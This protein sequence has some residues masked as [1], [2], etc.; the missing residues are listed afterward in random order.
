MMLLMT[1]LFGC[2]EEDLDTCSLSLVSSG[3]M[4]IDNGEGYVQEPDARWSSSDEMLS[5]YTIDHVSTLTLRAYGDE[6]G[7]EGADLLG[8]LPV[9][10]ELDTSQSGGGYDSG[11]S[12]WWGGSASSGTLTLIEHDAGSGL[13]SGCY[14]MF[15][16]GRSFF[17]GFNAL[18]E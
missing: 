10:L 2:A 12:G 13:L 11:T 6:D 14:R 18:E 4:T 5:I 16:D 9:I 1:A 17:G 15:I 3:T 8:A 7:N